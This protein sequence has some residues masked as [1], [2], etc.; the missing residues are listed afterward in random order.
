MFVTATPENAHTPPVRVLRLDELHGLAGHVGS[1]SPFLH[2]EDGMYVSNRATLG[3][4]IVLSNGYLLVHGIT[5]RAKSLV[6]HLAMLAPGVELRPGAEVAVGCAIG[7]K[8]T[9]GSNAFVGP[10]S[11]IEHGVRLGDHSN[12][13][14]H[15]FVGTPSI[16]AAET[17]LPAGTVVPPRT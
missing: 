7:I 10:C 2:L 8:T 12:I 16:V 6:G 1:R 14:C 11:T 9:L 4:N 15:S 17:K 13:G 3:T 5:L